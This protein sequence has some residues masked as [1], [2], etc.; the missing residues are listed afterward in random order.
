MDLEKSD[1]SELPTYVTKLMSYFNG[2]S[3]TTDMD[4]ATTDELQSFVDDSILSADTLNDALVA[5]SEKHVSLYFS[6]FVEPDANQTDI[7]ALFVS[8]NTIE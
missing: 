6:M 5:A 3:N 8:W 1:S 7:Y 4:V 2:C